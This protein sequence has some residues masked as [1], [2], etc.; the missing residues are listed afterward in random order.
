MHGLHACTAFSDACG[1]SVCVCV[2][3]NT[4][5]P[6]IQATAKAPSVVTMNKAIYL[7]Y[8]QLAVTYIPAAFIGYA[9]FGTLPHQGLGS[10]LSVRMLVCACINPCRC[11]SVHVF[12]FAHAGSAI[13]N[14]N[15]SSTRWRPCSFGAVV[16]QLRLVQDS[17]FPQLIPD[18]TFSINM[19][20]CFCN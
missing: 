4:I 16:A 17:W 9:C 18:K 3:R 8:A 6:E 19:G 12:V 11:E 2:C 15:D 20:C 14:G 10:F 1:M 13:P 5:I 7:L